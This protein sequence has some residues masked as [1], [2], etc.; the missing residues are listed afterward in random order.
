ML[1]T[2]G[3]RGEQRRQDRVWP[4]WAAP[5]GRGQSGRGGYPGTESQVTG[6]NP[7]YVTGFRTRPV[8]LLRSRRCHCPSL[9]YRTL[10][11][12]DACGGVSERE[13][14]LSVRTL[15]VAAVSALQ[16]EW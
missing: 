16:G 2:R 1:L 7:L 11:W 6:P 15:S 4:L 14:V 13:A 12:A 3:W 10:N 5:A 8:A 9:R